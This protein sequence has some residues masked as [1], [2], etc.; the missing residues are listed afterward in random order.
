[1]VELGSS[2]SNSNHAHPGCSGENSL[3]ALVCQKTEP[4]TGNTDSQVVF[5]IDRDARIQTEAPGLD[6]LVLCSKD[7][8]TMGRPFTV[9][10]SS[11]LLT[12]VLMLTE[13]LRVDE[14]QS[15][16]E[17]LALS[18]YNCPSP[19]LALQ[20]KM[21]PFLCPGQLHWPTVVLGSAVATCPTR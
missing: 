4:A 8:G 5:R 7:R 6:Y 3:F 18:G 2:Q 10:G 9:R 13:E 21:G 19:S 16:L 17:T 14:H 15:Q 12:L 20:S 1:M 11:L